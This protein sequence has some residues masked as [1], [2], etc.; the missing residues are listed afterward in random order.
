ME[1]QQQEPPLLPSSICLNIT[2]LLVHYSDVLIDLILVYLYQKENFNQTKITGSWITGFFL[3]FPNLLIVLFFSIF[4]LLK[5]QPSLKKSV[6]EICKI[7]AINL[8][9]LQILLCHLLSLITIRNKKTHVDLNSQTL[10][11]SY[12][13]QAIKFDYLIL[14]GNSF[15]ILFNNL[16]QVIVQSFFYLSKNIQNQR[17][18]ELIKI[19]FLKV[20]LSILRISFI[21]SYFIA[22]FLSKEL[23][24]KL[25]QIVFIIF[26]FFSNLLLTTVRLFSLVLI[27]LYFPKM[28]LLII[29]IR[30]ALNFS[31]VFFC[32]TSFSENFILNYQHSDSLKCT[33]FNSLRLFW[34][35]FIAIFKFVSYFE[36]YAFNKFYVLFHFIFNF[37]E[38]VLFV[39]FINLKFEAKIF[40]Y[41]LYFSICG[42]WSSFIIEIFYWKVIFKSKNAFFIKKF[43]NWLCCQTKM[44]IHDAIKSDDKL[45]SEEEQKVFIANS[46]S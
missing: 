5:K 26:R 6:F 29:C 46:I 13:N 9:H 40:H 32:L 43:Q 45:Y 41:F 36:D 7:A 11:D 12:Q 2:L 8:S 44:A 21:S 14:I 1:N 30:F 34:T 4:E 22:Y 39:I 33:S 37:V 3:M 24:V 18:H 38:S 25:N 42:L 15:H 35:F 23:N 20:V 28:C 31:I 10:N 27:F 19:Q 16:P 17:G